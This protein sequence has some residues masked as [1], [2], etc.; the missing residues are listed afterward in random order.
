MGDGS[1]GRLQGALD[2]SNDKLTELTSDIAT[3]KEEVQLLRVRESSLALQLNC[4]VR[5]LYYGGGEG[6]T[7]AA[8]EKGVA[9]RTFTK[10]TPHAH[11]NCSAAICTTRMAS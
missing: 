7:S 8:F 4:M 1:R 3:E 9:H 6:Y 10:L 5:L 11:R 2:K